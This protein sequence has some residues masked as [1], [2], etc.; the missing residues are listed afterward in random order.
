MTYPTDINEYRERPDAANA[1][2]DGDGV[3]WYKYTCSY[4]DSEN[5]EFAFSLW[6]KSIVDAE[7]RMDLIADNGKV[8]G[9]LILEVLEE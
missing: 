5:R 3:Q 1:F 6:A 7:L 8:D 4:N 2:M 9:Q